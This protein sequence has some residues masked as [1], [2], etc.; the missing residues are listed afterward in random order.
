MKYLSSVPMIAVAALLIAYL[1]S[2]GPLPGTV[3]RAG[4]TPPGSVAVPVIELPEITPI[5]QPMPTPAPKAV[6]KLNAAEMYVIQSDAA[7]V[8]RSFPDGLV[9]VTNEVGPV[10]LRGQFAG[11]NGKIVTKKYSKKQVTI[12]EACGVGRVALD[13]IPLG[14]KNEKDIIRVTLDVDSGQ[15]PQPPPKPD[16]PDVPVIAPPIDGDGFKVLIVYEAM[17]TNSLTPA[18]SNAIYGKALRDFLNSKCATG[19]DGKTREWRIFDKDV[20]TTSAP[21]Q[22]AKAMKRDRKSVPWIVVSNGK[23]GV[24]C[25]LPATEADIM[26]LLNKYAK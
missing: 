13:V 23:T 3:T 20:D 9:T 2:G 18:Q 24:E 5:P 8:V 14:F 10:T 12:V 7:F 22:W 21:P 17:D 6:T 15:G 19:T 25:P 16:D 4:D 1:A 26:A 11:G